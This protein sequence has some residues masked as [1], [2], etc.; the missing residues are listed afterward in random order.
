MA[1]QLAVITTFPNWAWD[2]YAK[3]M[4][5]S[6]VKY[7]PVEIPLLIELDDDCLVD[8]VKKILRPQDALA[9]GW[10]DEHKA[11]VERNKDKDSKDNY[12]KQAVRFC[13]K[14]F[15][16]KRALTAVEDGR[17]AGD[18]VARYL[19]WMDADVITKAQPVN[20]SECL[21]KQGDAVSYMGRKDWDHSECGWLA[22]DLENGGKEIIEDMFKCYIG[23][24]VMN[25]DQWHDSYVF[26][27]VAFSSKKTNLTH[28]KP[29]MDIW[30]CSPMGKWSVHYKGP[31]AKDKL[32]PEG[33]KI[34]KQKQ[35]PIQIKT[36]NAIPSEAIISNIRTNQ[37]LIKNWIMPCKKTNEEIVVVSAGPMLIP[38][39]LRPELAAGKRIVAVK[40]ALEPLLKAGIK[41]W[42]CILLDPREHV[43]KF[44]DEADKDIIWIIASQVDP[45]VT[46]KLLEKDCTIWGYHAAVGAGEYALTSKQ[47]YAIVCDGSATATR[48][49]YVLN[50][51][52]FK[53][54]KLYGY[55]LCYSEKPNLDL[56]D[57]KG[58]PKYLEISIGMHHPLHTV[59]RGF[60]TEGQL[61]AQYE[62]IKEI[63]N[64]GKM[65]LTAHGQGIIPFL[66]N[67]KAITDLRENE[68]KAKLAGK[69]L[70]TYR[71][72]FK[73]NK[74]KRTQLFSKWGRR[75]LMKL[76]LQM[77]RT[78]F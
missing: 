40:H 37:L 29:G 74:M 49:L 13:H 53:K 6:Y 47:P 17:A 70:L 56:R 77:R 55:D 23:D 78:S 73:C 63:M 33:S 27:Q 35:V 43:T 60:W 51:L 65:N 59:K 64:N 10:T 48:G 66:L 20:L 26:D 5:E 25:M 4:I 52:G 57:D 16:I 32:K 19:I 28:D 21:P 12:R 71:Q 58:Q 7:W 34:T 2:V 11:F 18:D 1:N 42:A 72:L 46:R 61:I 62:E 54:M 30:P 75:L 69:K 8:S 3:D 68:L 15:A 50:T 24:S 36:M 22:F 45:E 31:V 76:H 41:P 39:E 44:V 38:E 67:S 9:I 14:I